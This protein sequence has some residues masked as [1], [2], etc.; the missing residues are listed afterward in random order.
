MDGAE[1][2][3]EIVTIKKY[4]ILIL[5]YSLQLQHCCSY[6]E[7]RDAWRRVGSLISDGCREQGQ[8][9]THDFLIPDL[10]TQGAWSMDASH[11]K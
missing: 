2:E 7:W 9:H 11:S 3:L 4:V 10:L 5:P 1:S 6:N 8:V